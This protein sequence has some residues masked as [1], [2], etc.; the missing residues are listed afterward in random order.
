M[1]KQ[2][3]TKG[4]LFKRFNFSSPAPF[5]E[6]EYFEQSPPAAHFASERPGRKIIKLGNEELFPYLHKFRH[7][8]VQRCPV[9]FHFPER[10]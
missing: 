8:E 7:L 5:K 9:P 6:F 4:T 10:L 1:R 2:V 3:K